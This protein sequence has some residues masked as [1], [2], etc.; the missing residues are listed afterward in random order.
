[1]MMT[2]TDDKDDHLDINDTPD[3]WQSVIIL[4]LQ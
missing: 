3:V 1:M 4:Q 2:S